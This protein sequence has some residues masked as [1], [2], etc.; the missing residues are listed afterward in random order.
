MLFDHITHYYHSVPFRSLSALSKA[1]ALKVMEEMC[2]DTPFFERFKEPVQYWEN[3]TE[4]ENWL[5]E[6]FIQKG[7]KPKDKYPIYSVLGTAAWIEDYSSANGLAVEKVQ[8]PLS[9]FDDSDISFTFPDSMVSFWIARDRPEAYYQPDYHGHVFT[10]TE[11]KRLMT[12]ELMNNIELM[13]PE[14]TIPYVEAQI[15]NKNLARNYKP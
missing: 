8:I 15:W 3:R 10:L 11:I 7:G 1:E 4:T 13:H 12:R 2:D 6:S 9:I 5:R 14:G